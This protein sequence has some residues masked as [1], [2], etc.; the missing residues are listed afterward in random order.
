[1]SIPGVT[2]SDCITPGARLRCHLREKNAGKVIVGYENVKFMDV[3]CGFSIF[4]SLELIYWIVWF[5]LLSMWFRSLR[6]C[7]CCY[8]WLFRGCVIGVSVRF[9]FVLMHKT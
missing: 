5:L 8:K 2:A 4:V 3:L 1:M 7:L 6:L 9:I